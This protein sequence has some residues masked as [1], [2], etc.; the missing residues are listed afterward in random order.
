MI[1]DAE[2]LTGLPTQERLSVWVGK[3]CDIFENIKKYRKNQ[4]FFHIFDIYR[5]FAHTLLKYKIT[6]K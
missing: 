3:Y 2:L 4:I 1:L 5:E 6:T